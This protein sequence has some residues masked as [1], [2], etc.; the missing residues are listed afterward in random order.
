[1]RATTKI[2]PKDFEVILRNQRRF[3]RLNELL[4]KLSEVTDGIRPHLHLI[5]ITGEDEAGQD[6]T[7]TV[8]A[9]NVFS[10]VESAVQ[11]LC[12]KAQSQNTRLTK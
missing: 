10:A 4:D 3:E 5:E 6:T 11:E 8:D 9:E 7:V 2:S 1:M 12:A